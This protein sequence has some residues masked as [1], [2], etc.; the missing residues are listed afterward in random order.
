MPSTA[1]RGF[2]AL[3]ADILCPCAMMGIV[4]GPMQQDIYGV[5]FPP[6]PD[7]GKFRQPLYSAV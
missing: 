1:W 7:D 6:F 3:E 4:A 2:F 5:L